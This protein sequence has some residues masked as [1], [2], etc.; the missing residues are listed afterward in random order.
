MAGSAT[1][2]EIHEARAV[3]SELAPIDTWSKSIVALVGPNVDCMRNR[4]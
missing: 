4:E 1:C 2:A 3:L